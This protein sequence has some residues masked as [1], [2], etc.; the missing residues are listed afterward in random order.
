MRER[1]IISAVS[2]YPLPI[3]ENSSLAR[4]L[5]VDDE[6]MIRDLLREVLEKADYEVTE[7][8]DGLEALEAHKS[9]P[10]DLIVTD[11]MMP[12]KDGFAMIKELKA[13]DRNVKIVALTGFGLHNLPVAHDLGADRVFEKP[14]PTKEFVRTIGELLTG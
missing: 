8:A 4:I 3:M 13:V 6:E 9:Q 14:I 12:E 2:T 7:A 11:I 10:A 1:F 5:I